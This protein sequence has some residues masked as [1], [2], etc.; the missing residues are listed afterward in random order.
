MKIT[1]ILGFLL[2]SAAGSA[3]ATSCRD[4]ADS[5]S[6]SFGL[7]FKMNVAFGVSVGPEAKWGSTTE[8][9]WNELQKDY[10]Q[11][12]IA[13]C[14]S[15]QKKAI[16]KR[17][18]NR[19][20]KQLDERYAKAKLLREKMRVAAEKKFKEEI[21]KVEEK[22]AK[23]FEGLDHESAKYP[24]R[25]TPLAREQQ[26]FVKVANEISEETAKETEE[27]YKEI[28]AASPFGWEPGAPTSPTTPEGEQS[29]PAGT[30]EAP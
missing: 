8:M 4:M 13:I 5:R 3:K 22:A 24:S 29:K 16:S 10:S 25:E 27:R 7:G 1:L 28:K 11:K 17:E 21:A 30:D 26:A 23:A 9:H 12:F 20:L 18:Y 19:R 6:S 14:I 15:Y 2:I